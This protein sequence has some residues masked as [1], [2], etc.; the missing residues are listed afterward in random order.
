MPLRERHGIGRVP[1]YGHGQRAALQHVEL[2]TTDLA[3]AEQGWHRLLTTI[4]WRDG[5]AWEW[6]RTWTHPD[7]TY[8]VLEQSRSVRDAPHDRLR[9]GLDHLAVNCS[10]VDVLDSLRAEAG[11]NG[12]RE[13]FADQCPFAGGPS[14]AALFLENAQGFEVE[15]VAP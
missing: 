7:G 11:A 13:L 1:R 4:G 15:I 8:L 14:H 6:G 10:G 12:W 9:A 3:G 5:E 2:W